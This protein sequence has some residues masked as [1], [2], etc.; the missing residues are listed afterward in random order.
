KVM[1]SG[2][3]IALAAAGLVIGLTGTWS[4]CGFSM[5]ETIGTTGH[6]GG[7]P[8]AGTPPPP[9][10]PGDRAPRD[11]VP[12]RVLDDRDDRPDRSHRRPP[13]GDRRQP[14]LPPRRGRRGD[15][16]LRSAPPAGWGR[17]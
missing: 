11:V 16:D 2:L 9:C 12:V 8:R 5:I 15:G 7:A 6:S 1:L 10:R 13:D 3:E 17:P 4:P 14:D